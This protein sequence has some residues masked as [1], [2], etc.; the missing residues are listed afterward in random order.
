MIVQITGITNDKGHVLLKADQ[1]TGVLKTIGYPHSEIHAKSSYVLIYSGLADT[2]GVVELRIKVPDILKEYH[3]VVTIDVALA[4]TVNVWRPTTKTHVP[5]NALVPA[6][7]NDNE[8]PDSRVTV[9]HTPG[10]SQAGIPQ[11]GPIYVGSTSIS[12]RTD[13]GG[14]TGGRGERILQRGG[15]YLVQVTS[16]ADSNAITIYFDYYKHTNEEITTTT[17]TTTTS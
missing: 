17:T 1:L 5:G 13:T 7:R 2:D 10:G 16:R 6:N 9:C 11:I 3:A 8:L 4:A 14:N 12:G 15:T